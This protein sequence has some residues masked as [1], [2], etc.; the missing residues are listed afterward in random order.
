[1]KTLKGIR[2]GLRFTPPEWKISWKPAFSPTKVTH[3]LFCLESFVL[4]HPTQIMSLT[5][6]GQQTW[7]RE[8]QVPQKWL[9]AAFTDNVQVSK[10]IVTEML[11][12][13]LLEVRN[14][15]DDCS[16][17]Y[18][19][20]IIP[21]GTKSSEP[22]K[23]H[24]YNIDISQNIIL[25]GF[26]ASSKGMDFFFLIAYCLVYIEPDTLYLLL[27]TASGNTAVSNVPFSPRFIWSFL[28]FD[29]S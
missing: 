18:L 5:G 15:S 7:C 20:K 21:A 9:L 24:N 10:D 27:P 1:M 19:Q 4:L 29:D 11:H 2:V 14:K 23:G 17:K 3:R 26:T 22:T 28:L 8:L 25:W 13:P 6:T 16:S 12:L